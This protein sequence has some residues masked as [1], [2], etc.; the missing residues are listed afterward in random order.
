[1]FMNVAFGIKM[2]GYLDSLDNSSFLRLG[3]LYNKSTSHRQLLFSIK[4]SS[5]FIEQA[6]RCGCRASCQ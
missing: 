5:F 1:M 6:V 2:E 3:L 4:N